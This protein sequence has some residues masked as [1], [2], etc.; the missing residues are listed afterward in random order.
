[1]EYIS[2]FDKGLAAQIQRLPPWTGPLMRWVSVLGEPEIVLAVGF[3]GF[4]SSIRH[5]QP[6]V[7][8]ALIYGTVAFCLA[9][10]L[11]TLLRR[12]RPDNLKIQTLGIKSYSFPSGHAFG[13]VIFYGLLAILAIKFVAWP[14]N[15]IISLLIGS[16]IV[17]VGVSRVY[18][19]AH[20]PSDVVGGWLLGGLALLVISRL[21]F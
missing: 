20:Y 21:S 17:L 19:R 13:T 8:K 14:L 10:L 6:V 12:G 5:G 2:N 16:I 7:S 9:I 4:L 15:L 1:V 11:K 18:L 3:G